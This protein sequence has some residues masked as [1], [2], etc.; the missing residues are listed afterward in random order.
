MKKD[1]RDHRHNYLIEYGRENVELNI[2]L[3]VVNELKR[4]QR[5]E[6]QREKAARL[7]RV[8]QPYAKSGVTTVKIPAIGN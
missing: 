8:L 6:D 2:N 4:P 5:I 7:R 3:T 1:R